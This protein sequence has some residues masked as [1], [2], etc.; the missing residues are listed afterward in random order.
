VILRRSADHCRA[1]DVDV[2]DSVIDGRV[3]ASDSL[4]ERVQ[5]HGKQVDRLDAVFVHH[6]FVGA[7]ATQEPAMNDWVQRFYAPIHN[8]GKPGFLGNFDNIDAR[9][10]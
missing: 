7:A 5:I 6:V 4:F 9:V 1:T 10:A 8:L 2:F 3:F